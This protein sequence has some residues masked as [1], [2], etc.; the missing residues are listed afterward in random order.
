MESPP[1]A[2][3]VFEAGAGLSWRTLSHHTVN[4]AAVDAEPRVAILASTYS[5]R[6]SAKIGPA[7]LPRARLDFSRLCLATLFNIRRPAAFEWR[8]VCSVCKVRIFL[9][10]VFSGVVG[11]VF[12]WT[13]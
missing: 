10:R 4:T 9:D 8:D 13:P 11:H 12:R 3:V 5:Q 1:V 7:G 2:V 6:K